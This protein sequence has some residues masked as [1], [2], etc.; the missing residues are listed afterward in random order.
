MMRTPAWPNCMPCRD[1]ELQ[2][3]RECIHHNSRVT[4]QGQNR[5]CRHHPQ[6][7]HEEWNIRS[8]IGVRRMRTRDRES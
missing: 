4:H 3:L 8:N 1:P 7:Q 6:E 5:H 2:D